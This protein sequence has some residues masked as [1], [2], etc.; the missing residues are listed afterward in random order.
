MVFL[1]QFEEYAN[2]SGYTQN[3]I[4]MN[5]DSLKIL[6]K[7]TW[8]KNLKNSPDYFGYNY[9][10]INFDNIYNKI[11]NT[12][13]YDHGGKKN[14]ETLT[15]YDNNGK[16]L[17]YK[18]KDEANQSITKLYMVDT[19]ILKKINQ[20]FVNAT[21]I[22]KGKIFTKLPDRTI[23]KIF[24]EIN[25]ILFIDDKYETFLRHLKFE[26]LEPVNVNENESHATRYMKNELVKGKNAADKYYFHT[27]FFMKLI[28]IFIEEINESNRDKNFF[29]SIYENEI[30]LELEKLKDNVRK[31]KSKKRKKPDQVQTQKETK[32]QKQMQEETK[33]Q[34]QM[35][36]EEAQKKREEEAQN[37]REEEAQK[38]REEEAAPPA[39]KPA[40]TPSPPAETTVA[41][42][43]DE[44]Q[45]DTDRKDDSQ[46]GP[47]GIPVAGERDENQGDTD[48]KDDSLRT[49]LLEVNEDT[50]AGIN[51]INPGEQKD[52]AAPAKRPVTAPLKTLDKMDNVSVSS[53]SLY[54]VSDD[55]NESD[56]SDEENEEEEREEEYTSYTSD[57]SES[58]PETPPDNNLIDASNEN[59]INKDSLKNLND[60]LDNDIKEFRNSNPDSHVITL[61]IKNKNKILYPFF[62]EIKITSSIQDVNYPNKIENEILEKI[63]DDTYKYFKKSCFK[64]DSNDL[65]R[66]QKILIACEFILK[67]YNYLKNYNLAGHRNKAVIEKII[68]FYENLY[69]VFYKMTIK[70]FLNSD[71]FTYLNDE[72]IDNLIKLYGY[73]KDKKY[74][75][76]VICI[77]DNIL[78]KYY[79]KY[80]LENHELIIILKEE[81]TNKILSNI[82]NQENKNIIS[83]IFKFYFKN[84][85]DINC[86]EQRRA[87]TP[88]VDVSDDSDEEEDDA[89]TQANRP[90]TAPPATR[91]A[92]PAAT[93][94]T[95]ANRPKTAP[96]PA[97]KPAPPA[98]TPS[99]PATRPATAPKEK[100]QLK[101][102]FLLDLLFPNNINAGEAAEAQPQ[103]SVENKIL[104][105]IFEYDNEEIIKKRIKLLNANYNLDLQDNDI[106]LIAS[107]SDFAKGI[108]DT[109]Q[110][111]T[112]SNESYIT[113]RD[114]NTFIDFLANY[115]FSYNH[116]DINGDIKKLIKL[117]NK[118]GIIIDKETAR[119]IL[120][121]YFPK[122]QLD[123]SK[124]KYL[125]EKDDN[126]YVKP[127]NES[128]NLRA[129]NIFLKS[130]DKKDINNVFD[131]VYSDANH[132]N[133]HNEETKNVFKNLFSDSKGNFDI[134]SISKLF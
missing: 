129:F 39:I 33:R 53:P 45:G 57:S 75:I 96:T 102:L 4:D 88:D 32:R 95:Q 108:L 72:D 3:E 43:R 59:F 126:N 80:R 78:N 89:A 30:E 71:N 85:N 114:V 76:H 93:Q 63:I 7:I 27:K 90:K 26:Y 2:Y 62:K 115:K 29:Q 17:V 111:E 121:D 94:A 38:K 19:T 66:Y 84:I 110:Q 61:I 133:K 18:Y 37:K 49:Q 51:I 16:S 79:P 6:N 52:L 55:S 87:I 118:V 54:D 48:R 117:Y 77:T 67:F 22:Q 86:N 60:C 31:F 15:I 122:G 82:N 12:F 56:D 74:K 8:S 23:G 100:N 127:S 70:E 105:Y 47:V 64:P 109:K 21:E 11:V 123:K 134:S 132:H 107:N 50:T 116:I 112:S 24:E 103:T 65:S 10:K 104:N 106:K 5:I 92:P 131:I 36:E 1:K 14:N 101:T 124:L 46:G 68:E 120:N 41:G 44:N 81:F 125:Y 130:L 42:A 35:Q 91:P 99:P 34:K 28:T 97:I 40:P 58:S 9:A 73:I 98:P 69:N 128:E 13:F 119:T 83:K 20:L 113:T 25:N